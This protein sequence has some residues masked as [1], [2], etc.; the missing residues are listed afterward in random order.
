MSTILIPHQR[1]TADQITLALEAM[2]ISYLEG[3]IQPKPKPTHPQIRLT[4]PQELA[5]ITGFLTGQP[6]NT[7]PFWVNPT[8]P[9]DPQFVLDF[10]IQNSHAAQDVEEMVREVWSNN[11]VMLWSNSYSSSSREIKQSLAHLYPPP[12]IIDVDLRDDCDVLSSLLQRVTGSEQLPVL[13]VGGDSMGTL[14]EIREKIKNG[15][16]Q[17]RMQAVGVV[18][19]GR[20]QRNGN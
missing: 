8:L 15:E 6:A 19:G 11:P 5:A 2:K 9:I 1:S 14:N 12:T 3:S 7:I 18:V 4:L 10:D 13:L 17:N 16:L 20:K